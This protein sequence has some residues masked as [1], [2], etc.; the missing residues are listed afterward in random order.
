MIYAPSRQLK[1]RTRSYK[2]TVATL[3]D[4]SVRYLKA[5]VVRLNKEEKKRRKQA[6]FWVSIVDQNKYQYR[7]R[8]RA[9]GP[10][11]GNYYDTP[12]DNATRYDL[13]IHKETLYS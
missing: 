10:R 2:G 5:E 13:Y 11:D 9:R 12:I 4:P 3:S 7:L 6:S 8:I 1:P